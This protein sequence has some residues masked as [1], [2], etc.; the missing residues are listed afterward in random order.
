MGWDYLGA[1]LDGDIK[2]HDIVLM[3]SLNGAQL[4][5]SKELDCWIYIWIIVNLPPDKCYRKLHV[6]PGGFIPGPNKPKNVDSFLFPGIHHLAALQAEGLQ[7]WNAQTDSRY[8]SNL[9]L[10]FTTTDGPGLVYWNGMVGHSGKNGCRMYYG[11]LSR[12]KMRGKHYYPALLK[13]RNR[14][15]QG[16]DHPDIDVFKLPPGGCTNYADHLSTII[17]APNQMQWDKQKTKTGLTKPPLILT[18]SIPWCP[19]VH[20]NGY[21]APCW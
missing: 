18:L 4:Y 7:I 20:D 12:Q 10:L 15:T 1:V 5:N 6:R 17:S 16:S 11:V 19:F 2:P 3:V 9:Y 21:H 8:I 13:P 14:C